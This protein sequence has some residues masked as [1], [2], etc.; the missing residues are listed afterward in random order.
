MPPASSMRVPNPTFKKIANGVP[1]LEVRMPLLFSE[2]V[3]TGR[4]TLNEFV[5]LT[6]TNA[7][8]IYGLYPRKGTICIGADADIA[9]WD[10]TWKR[11]ISQSMLHDAM[12]YTP[13]EGRSVTGWPRMVINRGRV[14]VEDETLK[15]DRGS[16]R[17]R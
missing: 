17:I 13:Y 7:A 11:T 9:I 16:G 14:I 5:A 2:G 12:D 6:A 15:V 3:G 4:L 1:G 8:K 10:P